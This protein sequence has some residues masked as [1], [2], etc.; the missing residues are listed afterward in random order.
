MLCIGAI[1][2]VLQILRARHQSVTRKHYVTPLG[3]IGKD[4]V[5]VQD[6][7]STSFYITV[8]LEMSSQ[9]DRKTYRLFRG[10]PSLHDNTEKII[11]V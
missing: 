5:S 4:L 2:E 1:A 6:A 9:M 8:L 11:E 7:K 3:C 10:I